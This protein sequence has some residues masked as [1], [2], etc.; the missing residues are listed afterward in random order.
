[1]SNKKIL[2]IEDDST[3]AG[4]LIENLSSDG[5]IVQVCTGAEAAFEQIKEGKPDIILTDLVLSNIDGFEILKILKESAHLS[6]IPVLVLS[7][8]GEKEDVDKAMSLGAHDFLVKA[9]L[10]LQEITD[11]VKKVLAE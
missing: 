10:S 9:N 5:Y 1:M 3:L 7:N 2:I 6:D 8:L 4:A 11:Q